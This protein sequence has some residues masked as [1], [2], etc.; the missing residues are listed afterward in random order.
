MTTKK[1]PKKKKST[2]VRLNPD[3]PRMVIARQ[4]VEEMLSKKPVK[5]KREKKEK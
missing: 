5:K 1:L 2:W 3:D 4:I